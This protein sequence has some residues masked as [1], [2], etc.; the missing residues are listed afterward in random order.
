LDYNKG[1]V[2]EVLAS[3][4]IVGPTPQPRARTA[5]QARAWEVEDNET[6][7]LTLIRKDDTKFGLLRASWGNFIPPTLTST[8]AI[9]AA[10]K[11]VE[12]SLVRMA[13]L[14]PSQMEGLTTLAWGAATDKGL[15]LGHIFSRADTVP[16]FNWSTRTPAPLRKVGGSWQYDDPLAPQLLA[17]SLL[18][19]SQLAGA[20]AILATTSGRGMV[21]GNPQYWHAMEAGLRHL[22]ALASDIVAAS[23]G[24]AGV[25]RV[26]V[27]NC[28][29]AVHMDLQLSFGA[30]A[31]HRMDQ[32]DSGTIPAHLLCAFIGAK[33][34]LTGALANARSVGLMV[35]A[36]VAATGGGYSQSA[37]QKRKLPTVTAA[38][39][40]SSAGG[41]GSS[42][43]GASSGSGTRRIDAD[44]RRRIIEMGCCVAQQM[45]KPC[46][47]GP[48]C[49]FRWRIC[50][51]Q[52]A[53]DHALPLLQMMAE[54]VADG[55]T[56]VLAE[57][58]AAGLPNLVVSP[59]YGIS[60]RGGTATRRIHDLT[61][62]HRPG[63]SINSAT[64]TTRLPPCAYGHAVQS[65]FNVMYR[66]R[67]GSP[68][69]HVYMRFDD[70][71]AAYRQMKLAAEHAPLFSYRMAG[72]VA[73]E[74][75][76]CFGWKSSPQLF[77]L[78]A[79]LIQAAMLQASLATPV[80]AEAKRIVADH[81]SVEVPGADV[82]IAPVKPDLGAVPMVLDERSG[83][84]VYY[85]VD[86]GVSLDTREPEQL[87]HMS[88]VLVD[89]HLALF[90]KP[91]NLDK[92]VPWTTRLHALGVIF[93]TVAFTVSL[94]EDKV[95]KLRAIV[96]EQYNANRAT[97]TVK[98]LKS[99]L[100]SLRH[101]AFCVRSGRYFLGRLQR[102]ANDGGFMSP[103]ST[104]ALTPGFHG[105][106]ELWRWAVGRL[107][108]SAS[109]SLPL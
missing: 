50:A 22:Q 32:G 91:P 103:S 2:D 36:C 15:L 68:R 84:I 67:L 80:S 60:K 99:L 19:L 37:G 66:L 54:N 46:R 90:S 89:I 64:D 35:A 1:E 23:L 31:R 82:V 104:V 42:S 14:S 29:E 75:R 43:A 24:D 4:G 81:Y 108:F 83:G 106:M 11:N 97:A 41:G 102:T 70:V 95:A 40:G 48:V 87:L 47:N 16:Q 53:P 6:G 25:S 109:I 77:D 94:P 10:L 49:E 17:S 85:H 73:V 63:D 30:L 13:D 26:V 28:L 57:A 51:A 78:F 100:G 61:R 33:A 52:Q 88:G 65:I 8:V 86:D 55:Q 38:G 72:L 92:A 44:E 69:G 3:Y 96:F 71:S 45:G 39:A 79:Q 56:V 7:G 18:Y 59:V 58:A 74:L 21:V 20:F 76:A 105:D 62:V 12:P 5:P 107:D 98:E 93:D 27:G 101:Y 34:V 9:Y